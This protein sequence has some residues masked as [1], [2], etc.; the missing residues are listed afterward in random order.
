MVVQ[1]L[2]VLEIIR[3]AKTGSTDSSV[4][5]DALSHWLNAKKITGFSVDAADTELQ[6]DSRAPR[7]GGGYILA[8]FGELYPEAPSPQAFDALIR[9]EMQKLPP[10]SQAGLRRIIGG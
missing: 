8:I 7:K 1:S 6:S 2:R 3:Y 4:S 5:N 10:D 9:R